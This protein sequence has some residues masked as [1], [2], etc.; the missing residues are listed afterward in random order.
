MTETPRLKLTRTLPITWGDTSIVLPVVQV[1]ATQKYRQVLVGGMAPPTVPLASESVE[2][3]VR[4][5]Y[6]D[7]PEMM[8]GTMGDP[9]QYA[10]LRF[11]P[12]TVDAL[13]KVAETEMRTAS[14]MTLLTFLL[15]RVPVEALEIDDEWEKDNDHSYGRDGV[16]VTVVKPKPQFGA[17]V[18]VGKPGESGWQHIGTAAN[19]RVE[20]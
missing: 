15:L 8:R 3:T 4:C 19:N 5:N 20:R 7:F 9:V 10:H 17:E 14:V 13:A 11:E 6:G 12:Y 2:I 16:W 1:V 18:Y